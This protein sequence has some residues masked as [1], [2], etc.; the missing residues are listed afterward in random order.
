MTPWAE[1]IADAMAASVSA[2]EYPAGGSGVGSPAAESPLLSQTTGHCRTAV[3]FPSS[4]AS[5]SRKRGTPGL[6][7]TTSCS[8]SVF[9]PAK[10]HS[11]APSRAT[12]T[13]PARRRGTSLPFQLW[14]ANA[15]QAAA[16][17]DAGEVAA[18]PSKTKTRSV[19]GT[20]RTMCGGS[21]RGLFVASTTV[22]IA[23]PV[24]RR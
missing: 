12:E 4:M 11:R 23:P 24:R 19:T 14:K 8:S 16:A 15:C 13:E 17:N 5:T 7:S 6:P 22:H 18:S 20:P 9:I 2:R 21:R 10:T 3:A 1:A